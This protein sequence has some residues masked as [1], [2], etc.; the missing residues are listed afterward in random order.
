MSRLSLALLLLAFATISPAPSAAAQEGATLTV[1]PVSQTLGPD[2][3]PFEVNVLVD[4]V[5]TANGLGGYA[6]VM[7]YNP[8]V[9]RALAIA[10]SGFLE[11]A[12]NPVNCPSSA[13]DND[14]G[15]LE[16]LCLT[17][18]IFEEPG[19]RTDEPTVLVRITFEPAGEG[20]SPLD[21]SGTSLIDPSG[22][23]LPV[24]TT[25]GQV[26]IGSGV[27]TAPTAPP[28]D[29]S[30]S[31]EDAG[32]DE[33]GGNTGLYVGLGVAVALAVAVVAVV[34]AVRV[35]RSPGGP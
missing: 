9:L 33:G 17:A 29:L 31:T 23:D 4:D 19:V 26:I 2:A 13:I 16:H 3:G 22:T 24:A 14:A 5:T 35:G 11:I 32:I 12:E 34:V 20:T 10:N 27:A 6:L 28:P 15:Q 1:D 7:S 25:N 30:P 8:D 21:I 18:P